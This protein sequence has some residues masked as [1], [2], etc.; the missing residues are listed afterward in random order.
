MAD[1]HHAEH[2]VSAFDNDLA[3]IEAKVMAMGGLV[4][5]Q[6][7]EAARVLVRRDM[8]EADRVMARDE[9]VDRLEGELDQMAVRL[10]ALRQP[11]A[12]DLRAVLAAIKVAGNLERIGDYAKNMAKRT[13]VLAT[14]PPVGDSAK[15]V[16]RMCRLVVSMVGDVLQAYVER[17]KDLAEAV[18][19]RDED[20]DQMHNTLFRALLTYMMEDPR[21]ITP[22]MHL[23]FIAKNVERMGDHV[24]AVA[25]QVWFL[26][27]GALPE[28][29]RP[30][31]DTTPFT[32]VSETGDLSV[33]ERG[34]LSVQERGDISLP[35]R[36]E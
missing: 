36:G 22:A 18:R 2:I 3:Q 15:T 7:T 14:V 29:E 5:N 11:M 28:G 33:P 4:E 23:L 21:N 10:I 34:D 17:D 1:T 35:E 30:K 8:D 13:H 12:Q 6:V 9:E 16:E 20:V 31:G 19:Q 25:E 24:T 27:E 32:M 26:V